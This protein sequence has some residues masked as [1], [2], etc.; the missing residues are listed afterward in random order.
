M[1]KAKPTPSRVPE[2]RVLPFRGTPVNSDRKDEEHQD[3][4]HTSDAKAENNKG[5]KRLYK[6]ANRD[7]IGELGEPTP[8][9]AEKKV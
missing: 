3:E 8:E 9:P 7:E 2:P 5:R 6:Q 4:G 1:T